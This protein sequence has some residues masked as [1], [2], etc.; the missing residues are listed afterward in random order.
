[1][2]S[3]WQKTNI[4]ELTETDWLVIAKNLKSTLPR[5]TFI[6]INGGEPLLRPKL[7]FDLI[8]ELKKHFKTVALNSNGFLIDNATI[9]QLEQ[10]GLDILKISFY[11]LR[12]EIHNNLRGEKLA[13]GHAL[14][15]IELASKSKIK[16]EIGILVTNQ[17]INELPELIT[18]LQ[19]LPNTVLILQPL[20]ESVESAETKNRKKIKL[21]TDLWPKA[22]EVKKTFEWLY[23]HRQN[24]K[25]S[26]PNLKA[27]EEY[28][29]NPN[30][31]LKYRCFAGQR[32]AV[33]YPNGQ[34]ALCFKGNILGN[35]KNQ[36]LKNLLK[37]ARV[38]RSLIKTC[39]KYCR[40]I[41]CNFS[42]GLRE[43][44]RDKTTKKT[45]E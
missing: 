24:I 41:G 45:A 28:Y 34:V 20:D 13:Y 42:R 32:N 35:I 10:A 19:K 33:I 3:I 23:S 16:L 26:L 2:C 4:N 7:V 18:Y 38:E 11:S 12:P 15:A 9:D 30:T 6:E 25:N 36:P 5:E 21:L 40:I 31:V 8:T 39:P 37:K 29:L 27:I 43:Y 44:W 14:R 22:E 1:M 17:N